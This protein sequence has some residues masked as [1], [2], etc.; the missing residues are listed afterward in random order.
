MLSRTLKCPRKGIKNIQAL[1]QWVEEI[2]VGKKK[3]GRMTLVPGISRGRVY[4]MQS[5]VI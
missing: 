2:P 3:M 4:K 1:K 5:E